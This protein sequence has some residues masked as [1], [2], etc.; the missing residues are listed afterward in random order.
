MRRTILLALLLA[1]SPARADGAFD[2]VS[3]GSVQQT[4][5]SP[6]SAW[7]ADKL[8]A[9]WD[10]SDAFQLRLD[11]TGTHAFGANPSSTA[12]FGDSGGNVLLANVAGEYQPDDHWSFRLGAGGSPTATT[13]T[14]TTVP[15]ATMTSAGTVDVDAK[16]GSTGWSAAGTGSV[17]YDTAGGGELELATVATATV[18]YFDTREDVSEVQRRDGQTLTTM[19]LADYCKTHTCSPQ[20]ESVLA[21][22]TSKL[23]Q[24]VLDGN[25][26]AQVFRTTDITLDFAYYVYDHDPT[27]V[28]YFA[29]ASAGRSSSGGGPQIAPL[30]FT[31]AP[32]LVHRF[33]QLAVIG[34]FSYGK[35]V[36]NEGYDMTSNLKV[37]YRFK[38][39]PEK[40]IKVWGKLVGSRDIDQT[41]AQ[42]LSGW[43]AT[44]VQYSW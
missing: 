29:L 17:G 4:A 13:S 42:I 12:P 44:G 3:A 37:Q 24:T 7:S 21:A 8:G 39:G 19:Q 36:D 30:W 18:N 9:M 25:V 1:R 2:E 32:A 15:F 33:G 28:G 35:Y 14:S 41:G 27:Q 40:R 20:L 31:V 43:A 5:T 11:V 16:L 26:T 22:Q 23:V 38:L 10:P 6:R 34:T